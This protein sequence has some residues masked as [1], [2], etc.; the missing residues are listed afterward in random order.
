M[1]IFQ[2]CSEFN[3]AADLKKK[4]LF[5][6]FKEIQSSEGPVVHMEDKAIVM[7]GSNNYLGLTVHPKVKAA[8]KNA[9]DEFG[10]ATSSSRFLTGT[11]DMHNRV[12]RKLA[13]FLGKEAGLIFGSG[14]LAG[15]GVISP[16]VERD[17]YLL[18]DR[19]N[20]TSMVV[21]AL[22][23]KAIGANTVRYRNNDM[24]D[25]E[26][27]L[28]RIPVGSNILIATDGVFSVTGELVNL[29]EL[30]RLANKYGAGLLIDDAHGFGVLGE[31]GR[32]TASHF[33]LLDEV[34]LIVCTFS[35]SLSSHGGFVAGKKEV[36]NYLKH[37]SPAF[38]FSSASPP[39]VIAT[40]ESALDIM[41]E[42]P[43]LGSKV[44]EN[45]AYVRD[46]LMR[47]GFNVIEGETGIVPILTGDDNLT[48]QFW[49]RLFDEGVYSN[50]FVCPGVAPGSQ[51]IRTSYMASH[52]KKHLQFVI[53]TFAKVGT[54][55]GLINAQSYLDNLIS[56][57]IS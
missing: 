3:R 46:G 34:D 27:R 18:S 44:R 35:K 4:G 33:G 57:K 55:L 21:G 25:L 41:I 45:A 30:V 14:Y 51:I 5:P 1:N 29:N 26:R 40:V 10:T 13:A 32:G 9:I 49:R 53:D 52:E 7:A 37:K 38:M 22:M 19:D 12:E 47:L 11:L 48:F 56:T 39:S 50:A 16:L 20:H 15:Q 6:Y 42:Q 31:G 24:K 23:Q 17:D 43:D 2:K 36:I 54:E 8:A 28:S